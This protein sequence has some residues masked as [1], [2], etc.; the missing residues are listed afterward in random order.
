MINAT[1]IG[2][3]GSDP[4]LKYTDDGKAIATFSLAISDKYKKDGVLVSETMWLRV[5]AFGP[6]AENVVALYVKK[7]K[8]VA[9]TVNR[10]RQHSYKST[11]DETWQI[12]NDVTANGIELLGKRDD[13]LTDDDDDAPPVF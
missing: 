1:L 10:W 2:H 8:Q 3:V 13:V 4:E 9:V 6:L 5:T 11:R 7:G 12:S